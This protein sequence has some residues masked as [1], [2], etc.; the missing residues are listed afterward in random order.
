MPC[1]KKANR[2]KRDNQ[3]IE[4]VIVKGATGS[5]RYQAIRTDA[6]RRAKLDNQALVCAKCG[7]DKHVEVCHIKPISSFDK[8]TPLGIVNGKENL[9]LL[10][11]NC[12]WEHDNLQRVQEA[13][14]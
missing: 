13:E 4:D 11:P 3:A 8:S 1:Y 12:H 9:M 5:H 7:Y 2:L 10:C 14:R 6:I